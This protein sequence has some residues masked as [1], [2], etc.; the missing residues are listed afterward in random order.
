MDFIF[1]E[2]FKNILIVILII[3]IFGLCGF[4]LFFKE[5]CID[6][7]NNIVVE[8]EEE[9]KNDEILEEKVSD[10]KYYVD[11][12][13]AVKKPGVYEIEKG[14]IVNDVIKIAGGL[15]VMHLLNLLI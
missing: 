8:D 2:K 10:E 1:E 12:K 6:N 15:K 11:I 13:G 14:S 4:L 9:I 5:D 3:I 7:S